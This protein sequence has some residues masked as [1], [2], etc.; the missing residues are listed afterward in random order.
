VPYTA[1]VNRDNRIPFLPINLVFNVQ[2]FKKFPVSP[3][4]LLQG[5]YQEGL[6]ETPGPGQEKRLPALNQRKYL[7]GLV[8]VEITAFP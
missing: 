5:A 6:A 1:P 3:E 4:N 2:A 8:N 7:P